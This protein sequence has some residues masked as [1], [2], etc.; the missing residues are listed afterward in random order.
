MLILS[1]PFSLLLCVHSSF[2][3]L[4]YLGIYLM[5]SKRG[6]LTSTFLNVCKI[7]LST[8]SI[9]YLGITLGGKGR[10]MEGIKNVEGRAT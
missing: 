1:L 10:V 7:S 2:K 5:A 9:I 4:A 6:T 3:N 8:T